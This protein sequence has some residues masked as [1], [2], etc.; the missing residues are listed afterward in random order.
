MKSLKNIT[1]LFLL[2]LVSHPVYSDTPFGFKGLKAGLVST[3]FYNINSKYKLG[4]I[5]GVYGDK[6]LTNNAC[7]SW[8]VVFTS[9]GGIIQRVPV[10]IDWEYENLKLNV[11]DIHC[12]VGFLEI[13]ILLKIAVPIQDKLS[14][15]LL[16][17]P[18]ISSARIDYSSLKNDKIF[19][20]TEEEYLEKLRKYNMYLYYGELYSPNQL[21]KS[22]RLGFNWGIGLKYKQ[23]ILESRYNTLYQELGRLGNIYAIF[24][25]TYSIQFILNVDLI[26]PK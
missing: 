11:Y 5:I 1:C 16:S 26:D 13:P 8:E 24:Q 14:V 4:Y 20:G 12:S 22:L 21:D 25:R 7:L 23:F 19:S 15:I 17:G 2:F 9:R 3:N 6:Y 18:S 10:I